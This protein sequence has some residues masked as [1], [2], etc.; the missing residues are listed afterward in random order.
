MYF[1]TKT[2][3]PLVTTPDRAFLLSIFSLLKPIFHSHYQ[4]SPNPPCQVGTTA[5][6]LKHRFVY[7][8]KYDTSQHQQIN[9][10][11]EK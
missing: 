8:L 9:K 3:E 6:C 4:M 10:H 1:Q 11:S 7:M 5:I 2:P